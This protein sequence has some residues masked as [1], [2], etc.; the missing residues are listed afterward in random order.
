[1]TFTTK[2]ADLFNGT[3]VPTVKVEEGILIFDRKSMDIPSF[4][5]K[6]TQCS[7]SVVLWVDLKRLKSLSQYWLSK[8][9]SSALKAPGAYV[10]SSHINM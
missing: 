4:L 7:E 9:L 8:F 10:I 3:N 5:L 1:M 2:S 6:R